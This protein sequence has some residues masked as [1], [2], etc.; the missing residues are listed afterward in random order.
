MQ[1]RSYHSMTSSGAADR[2]P[3]M[4]WRT[5]TFSFSSSAGYR[6]SATSRS[7]GRLFV[8]SC[9]CKFRRLVSV[10]THAC[11]LTSIFGQPDTASGRSRL[12]YCSSTRVTTIMTGN[13]AQQSARQNAE[14]IKRRPNARS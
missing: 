14:R 6:C 1:C 12:S 3:E 8:D 5:A 13:N 7:Q 2:K 11:G 4:S 10:F 9:L